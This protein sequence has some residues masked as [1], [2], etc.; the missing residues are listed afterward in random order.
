MYVACTMNYL[1]KRYAVWE[2]AQ[3]AIVNTSQF[4]TLKLFITLYFIYDDCLAFYLIKFV[5]DLQSLHF[6]C[7]IAGIYSHSVKVK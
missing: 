5:C 1:F 2:C 6:S 7:E 3:G 4:N